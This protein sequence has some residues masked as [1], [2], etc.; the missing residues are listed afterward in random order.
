MKYT[1]EQINSYLSHISLSGKRFKPS[2]PEKPRSA[3]ALKYLS[4]L[5]KCHLA[6]IPFENLSLHYSQ[7]RIISLD[8]EDLFEKMI[9]SKRG[10]GGY[11]MEQNL[12]F[13]T[14]LKSLGFEVISTGARVMGS[15]NYNG[16]DHQV[17]LVCMDSGVY[18]VDVGFGSSGPTR[19]IHLTHGET[20][21]W[22]ATDAESRLI[23]QEPS[24]PVMQG[25]WVMQHRNT[26]LDDWTTKYC[27]GMT[28]FTAQDF[29]VM[30]YATSTRRT[31]MFTYM[32]L[33]S[34]MIFDEG[35]DD[36]VGAVT[37]SGATVK[38]RIRQ[39]SEVVVKCATEEERVGALKEH[40]G[41]VLSS[42]ERAGIRGIVSELKG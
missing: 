10:R 30:N 42:R 1:T 31:S 15:E 25:L 8:L 22:G 34:K 11:C 18:V 5:Q 21:K 24:N 20:V 26:T 28:E 14:I 3:D 17:L 29:E 7:D 12:F 13:G 27:F 37:L 23:Y 32:V 40:F 16:W 33:G 35:L 36:I 6:S 9:G 4:I 39:K 38:K 41:L 2:V 19:P